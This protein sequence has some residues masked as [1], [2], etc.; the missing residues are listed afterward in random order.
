MTI[1][2]RKNSKG[3][4]AYLSI[5]YGREAGERMATGIFI[6]THPSNQVEKNHNKEALL[7]AETKKSEMMLERQATGTGFIPSHKFKANF[8]DYYQE[9]IQFNRR[10]GNRHLANSLTQFKLFLRKDFISPVDVTENLC[11]RFRKFLL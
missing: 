9:F 6:Y 1:V 4:K 3:D 8:L 11:H 10:V 5:A 2:Q 7:L